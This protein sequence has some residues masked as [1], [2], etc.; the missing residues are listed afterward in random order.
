MDDGRPPAR[1][2]AYAL[3]LTALCSGGASAQDGKDAA[4]DNDEASIAKA[5]LDNPTIKRT[6]ILND[7][8]IVF[9]TRDDSIYNNQLPRQCPSL[10]R[11]ALVNYAVANRQLCAGSQFQVLWQTG[12]GNYTPAF[13]CQL[14]AFVPITEADLQDLTTMTDED[15]DRRRSR[16]R[17][18][19]E[20]VTSEQVE[21]P[22][23]AEPA[24]AAPA[25]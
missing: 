21:L 18:A 1:T 14:G 2:V 22:P 7:R 12:T 16:K 9:I 17:S 10:R 15:R 8:N 13:T 3:L 5:C 24:P 25:E 20:A 6:Q 23:R 11:G 19:R 4:A